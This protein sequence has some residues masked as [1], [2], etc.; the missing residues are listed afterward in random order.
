MWWYKF[1]A[2][3]LF[4]S[5]F[6]GKAQLNN[7][8][9]DDGT[10]EGW[11]W[12]YYHDSI[13]SE[14]LSLNIIIVNPDHFIP[15]LFQLNDSLFHTSHAARSNK[16]TFAI[17][18]GFFNVKEGGSA[19]FFQDEGKI[20]SGK[21]NDNS[22]I[23]KN[24]IAIKSNGTV[25]FLEKPK[26]GWIRLGKYKDILA[27]GPL[28]IMENID[29]PIDTIPFNTKRHPRSAIGQTKEGKIILLTADGRNNQSVGL[30][31]NELQ[32]LMKE[33]GCIN[34]INLDGGGSSTLFI[35]GRTENG[36][37]NY[38]SDNKTFDHYGERKVGSILLFKEKRN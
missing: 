12:Y 28:L 32:T 1:L 16:A 19:S 18:A 30:T 34:A 10:Q 20:V 27:T 5:F 4:I 38:P 13:N 37:V 35:N 26:N 8:Q 7:P 17:N 6:Q 29:L 23:S 36:V 11:H 9:I 31:I 22:F 21:V 24:A 33:L 15:D 2:F 3:L 25:H 14:P